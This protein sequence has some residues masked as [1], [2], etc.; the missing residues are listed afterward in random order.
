LLLRPFTL[1]LQGR[2]LEIKSF[3]HTLPLRWKGQAQGRRLTLSRSQA[4]R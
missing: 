2:Y 3:N 4:S 1:S